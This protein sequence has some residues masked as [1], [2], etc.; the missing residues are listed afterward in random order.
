MKGLLVFFPNDRRIVLSAWN[1]QDLT[2]MVLP[3]CHMFAQFYVA[4]G[5]LSCQMYQRSCDMGLG[6]PF[7]VASYSLFTILLAFICNLKPKE[8][9]H[10][11]GDTHVYNNHIE[12]LTEQI[13]RIPYEFPTLEIRKP[14]S[15]DLH[16]LL[17]IVF[18]VF[19]VPNTGL[20]LLCFL[21]KTNFA[22]PKPFHLYK[23]FTKELNN[24]TTNQQTNKNVTR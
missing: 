10:V 4:N 18:P 19:F 22:L 13:S 17:L 20:F 8:F 2:E 11:L 3:P 15:N 23:T 16:V 21:P 24:R 12:G 6:I 14:Y 9:I 5:E 1:P 7:N